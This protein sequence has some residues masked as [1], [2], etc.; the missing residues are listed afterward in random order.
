[1]YLMPA[2]CQLYFGLI[3]LSCWSWYSLQFQWRDPS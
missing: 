1:M 2:F 3:F